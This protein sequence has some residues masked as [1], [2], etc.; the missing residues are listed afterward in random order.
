MYLL[1]VKMSHSLLKMYAAVSGGR[2]GGWNGNANGYVCEEERN[3]YPPTQSVK[4][5]SH[6]NLK[7]SVMLM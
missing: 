3:V 7:Y 6:Y 2:G 5:K 4:T 1:K